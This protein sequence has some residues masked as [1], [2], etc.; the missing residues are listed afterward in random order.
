MDQSI[1]T[2]LKLGFVGLLYVFFLGVLSVVWAELKPP[3]PVPAAGAS[4]RT[5]P[6]TKRDS[7]ARLGRSA[8]LGRGGE[9]QSPP[10]ALVMVEP[11]D[12]RGRPFPLLAEMTVGR[13]AGCN[14]ALGS[15]TTVSQLHARIF[16]DPE[17]RLMVE[18]LGS[19]NGTWLNRRKVTAPVPMRRG[20]RLQFGA[21][22]FEIGGEHVAGRKGART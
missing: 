17:G 12:Q 18:D 4:R 22:V 21:T 2:I 5:R 7:S 14:I 10:T 19:T 13:A 15:D 1:L 8:I 9:A 16:T 3:A 20:D 6:Q 11:P